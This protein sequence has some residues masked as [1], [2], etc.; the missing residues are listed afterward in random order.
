M[1]KKGKSLWF[2]LLSHHSSSKLHRTI[3]LRVIK[4]D[5]YLCARCTGIFLGFVTSFFLFGTISSLAAFVM[6]ALFPLPAAAD[7]ITQTLGIR[8]S[9]NWIR[10]GTGYLLGITWGFLFSFLLRGYLSMFLCAL[11]VLAIYYGVVYVIARKT[12]MLR[13]YFHGL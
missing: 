2:Y 8:E 9:K 1:G 3:H 4:K 5:I 13:N 6:M 7:W 11:L 10:V 12:G